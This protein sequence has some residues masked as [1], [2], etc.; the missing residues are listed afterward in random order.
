MMRLG[1][2]IGVNIGWDGASEWDDAVEQDGANEWEWRLD[3]TN[4]PFQ[5]GSCHSSAQ[6]AECAA[7]VIQHARRVGVPPSSSGPHSLRPFCH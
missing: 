7:Q 1:P 6:W 3:P 5:W 2:V 4:W